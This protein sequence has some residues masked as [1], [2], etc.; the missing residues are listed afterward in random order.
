MITCKAKYKKEVKGK[1]KEVKCTEEAYALSST[2]EQKDYPFK[3]DDTKYVRT[4][5]WKC[6]L[7]HISETT[8][9]MT[10]LQIHPKVEP[11]KDT[12]HKRFKRKGF[13]GHKIGDSK[14]TPTRNDGLTNHQ[15]AL[16]NNR[17]RRQRYEATMIAKYG[18]L[19]AW[20]EKQR[21]WGRKGDSRPGGKANPQFKLNPEL[22]SAAGKKSKRGASE[23]NAA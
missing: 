21:E 12:S 23:S 15:R 17:I 22:A 9:E 14:L 2:D 11:V 3:G 19:E 13:K 8:R 4:T 1:L 5:R 20:Q 16:N 10:Y 18:S 7:G 6:P